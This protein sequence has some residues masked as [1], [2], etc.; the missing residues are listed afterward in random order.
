MKAMS[1]MKELNKQGE[2]KKNKPN[3]SKMTRSAS[4][5]FQ[6]SLT[7][8][9]PDRKEKPSVAPKDSEPCSYVYAE[10]YDKVFYRTTDMQKGYDEMVNVFTTVCF[11]IGVF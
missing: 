2:L 4:S 6:S 7:P 1:V 8:K 5:I 10:S 11:Y 3:E 9:N